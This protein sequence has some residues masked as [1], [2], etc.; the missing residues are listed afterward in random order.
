MPDLQQTYLVQQQEILREIRDEIRLGRT[1][2][3]GASS[4]GAA[5]PSAGGPGRPS[6]EFIRAQTAIDRGMA[7]E[8]SGMGWTAAYKPTIDRSLMA[9]LSASLGF[10]RAPSTM[11]QYEFEQL[12]GEMMW[13]TLSDIPARAFAPGM[14]GRTRARTDAVYQHAARF[15]RAGDAGAGLLGVGM[16]MS[17]AREFSLDLERQ[18]S[19][20]MRFTS[21]QYST[22]LQTGMQHGQF[23]FAQTTAQMRQKFEELRDSIGDLT[24]VT[25]M[26][27]EQIS[28]SMGA[29]R[30]AG[31]IDV[32]EQSRIIQRI[33]ASARVA[34]VSPAEMQQV[35]GR[36]IQ[37]AVQTGMDVFGAG[38]LASGNLASIRGMTR[39]GTISQ[40][41]MAAGGG[42]QGISGRITQAQQQFL[43]SD[44]GLLS[45]MGGAGGGTGALDAL[46]GGVA[47][48]G[49]LD[50]LLSFQANRL[51]VAQQ[52]TSDPRR[53]REAYR[54]HIAMQVG[55]MGI[56]DVESERGRDAAFMVLRGQMGDAAAH[57]FV[58]QNFTREG[59]IIDERSDIATLRYERAR[60]RALEHDY[61]Y[62][63]TAP[64]ARARRAIQEIA[65]APGR[66]LT[67]AQSWGNMGAGARYARRAE[68]QALGLID[69]EAALIDEAAALMGDLGGAGGMGPTR[70]LAF[71]PGRNQGA[72]IIGAGVIGSGGMLAGALL[73]AKIGSFVPIPVVGTAAGALIGGAVGA[74]YGSSAGY[75]AG[76]I[77]AE[78]LVGTT[79]VSG[80]KTI[81]QFMALH[82]AAQMNVGRARS[83]GGRIMR[84]TDLANDTL[85]QSLVREA[86][87][88]GRDLLSTQ[89]A[90]ET[91]AQKHNLSTSDVVLA[92]RAMGLE[93]DMSDVVTTTS[94]GQE[95][96]ETLV[97]GVIDRAEG[98]S[99]AD[100]ATASGAR[101]LHSLFTNQRGEGWREARQQM[102]AR[103]YTGPVLR[104][105]E[106]GFLRLSQEDRDN[107]L[108][109]LEAQAQSGG[110]R[111]INE[112]M[113]TLLAH[114][115]RRG[116][117]LQFLEHLD[118][119]GMRAIIM[120]DDDDSKRRRKMLA[121]QSDFFAGVH[122]VMDLSEADL[123]ALGDAEIAG[124]SEG[125]LSADHVRQFREMAGGNVGQFR[126][127]LGAAATNLENME[128]EMSKVDEVKMTENI[129]NA[130]RILREISGK[131]NLSTGESRG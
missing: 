34:G 128:D 88:T 118:A 82:S 127:L 1:G 37:T 49:N 63:D 78:E 126:A 43:A 125:L 10:A 53:L 112:R 75:T 122:G 2:G 123:S 48:V 17:E 105:L 13:H 87:M 56:G 108:E 100:L 79:G 19:R 73:G 96:L 89:S 33:D 12:S 85:F 22:I 84:E 50:S 9:T 97:R 36:A 92:A 20:D 31:I 47:S 131:L 46:L 113:E 64:M 107:V 62:L 81:D 24:R 77:L 90:I 119:E 3:A 26:S 116:G 93:F 86:E 55:M 106:Q 35:V 28:E 91:I 51:D 83:D 115:R 11:T 104:Q 6:P 54:D 23:D 69:D 80:Q 71:R 42:A 59:R 27:T 32:A 7:S 38:A 30:Q 117:N 74:F 58:R 68:M 98:V 4:P 76:E 101:D 29:L 120:G 70:S 94:R 52:L 18:A 14:V 111:A 130:A 61:E 72:G 5:P 65:G 16:D 45:L 21:G 110:T 114:A 44:T 109:S 57:T 121:G 102:I 15:M 99:G 39:A 129:E 40:A 66:A 8:W 124:R 95:T 25:R 41:V 67:Y 103:G 60:D